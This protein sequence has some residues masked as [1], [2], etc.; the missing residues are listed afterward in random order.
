VGALILRRN[1]T[2]ALENLY[3]EMSKAVSA[4]TYIDYLAQ[5]QAAARKAYNLVLDAA[6]LDFHGAPFA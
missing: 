4:K 5:K 3:A 6:S 1:A 2:E